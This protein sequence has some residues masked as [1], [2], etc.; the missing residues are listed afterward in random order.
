MVLIF[1]ASRHTLFTKK[2]YNI[3]DCSRDRMHRKPQRGF[4][5]GGGNVCLITKTQMEKKMQ[6]YGI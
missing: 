2:Q 3:P 5:N 4:K 6:A 1:C